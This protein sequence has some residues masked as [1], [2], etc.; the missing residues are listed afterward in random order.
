VKQGDHKN[1]NKSKLTGEWTFDLTME[2]ADI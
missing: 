2:V 1:M